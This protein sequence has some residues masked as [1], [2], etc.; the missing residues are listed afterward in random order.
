MDLLAEATDGRVTEAQ[1]ATHGATVGKPVG[2]DVW[3]SHELPSKGW[4]NIGDM[5]KRTPPDGVIYG[6]VSLY[7]PREQETTMYIGS[8]HG[9]KV[10]LNG[11]LISEHLD[12]WWNNSYSK[13]L[14]VT[15][16]QGRNVLL[17]TVATRSDE[18]SNAFFGFESGT[19]YTVGTGV[20]YVVSETPIYLGDTFTFDVRAENV[21]DMAGWQFD[22][23]F[24]PFVL[25]ALE[26][27]EGVFLKSDAGTTFFQSGSIDNENGKITGLS[28]ARLTK[29]GIS[30]SGTV[31]QVRFKA[32][33]GGETT[34]ALQRFQF[35]SVA[36]GR[37]PRRTA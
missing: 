33:F 26:V 35:G 14:P 9:I 36:G 1:V 34:L 17:V 19:E 4:N 32:L 11:A 5:L 29:S 16:R 30:G 13:F 23:V 18:R 12:G 24:D 28:A 10:W 20:G 27:S 2:N 8:I 21:V 7:S 6:S 31:L 15:L 25:E 22:I 37:Y 3:T